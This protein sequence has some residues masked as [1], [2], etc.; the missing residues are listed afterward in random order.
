MKGR[1]IAWTVLAVMVAGTAPAALAEQTA[2]PS[3]SG[4]AM[5][6][7]AA[8]PTSASAVVTPKTSLAEGSIATLQLQATPPS[9]TLAGSEGKTWTLIIDPK[10]TTVW[11]S[12]QMAKLEQ[13]TV[14]QR[15]RVRYAEQDGKSVITS[16]QIQPASG[17]TAA[18][19]A[20]TKSN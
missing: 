12:G 20:P 18:A 4:S 14:G 2:K 19:P 7:S 11:E 15:A 9:L 3:N 17:P 8:A 16:V 1:W 13:L 6:Q 10:S 5:T